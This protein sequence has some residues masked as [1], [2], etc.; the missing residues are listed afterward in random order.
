MKYLFWLCFSFKGR[1]NRETYWLY[2]FGSWIVFALAGS[3][4]DINTEPPAPLFHVLLFVKVY[5]MDMSVFTKRLHDIGESWRWWGLLFI[6]VPITI[7]AWIT[8][9]LVKGEEN[10]N[11]FGPPPG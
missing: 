2:G 1:V 11:R 9:G 4:L 6:V 7:I 3:L 8:I 5:V 10:E